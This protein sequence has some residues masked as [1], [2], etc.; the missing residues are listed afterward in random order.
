M[1]Y[2]FRINDKMSDRG[3]P[4][5]SGKNREGG[6]GR[7]DFMMEMMYSHYLNNKLKASVPRSPRAPI[8]PVMEHLQGARTKRIVFYFLQITEI[9]NGRCL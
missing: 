5:D 2:Q 6:Q 1:D 4:F 9:R 3:Y 7:S 8:V